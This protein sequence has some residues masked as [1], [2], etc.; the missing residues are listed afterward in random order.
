MA[1]PA[2]SNTLDHMASVTRLNVRTVRILGQNPSAFTLQGACGGADLGTNTYLVMPPCDWN[3]DDRSTLLPAIL[4][5]TGDARED[6]VPYLEQ[7]LRGNLSMLDEGNGPVRLAL[8]DMCVGV[9]H[10]VS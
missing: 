7:V 9:A 10:P 8:T 3:F 5:D 1:R 4:I 6:Y 2:V